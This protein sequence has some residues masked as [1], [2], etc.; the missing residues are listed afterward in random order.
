MLY[1]TTYEPNDLKNFEEAI[2]REESARWK[3]AMKA[4]LFSMAINET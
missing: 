3:E 2:N 1:Q 4:E